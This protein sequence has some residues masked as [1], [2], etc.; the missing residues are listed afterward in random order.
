MKAGLTQKEIADQL[1]RNPSAISRELKRNLG[2]RGYRPAQ[3]QRFRDNRKRN[4]HKAIKLT[5]E[6]VCWIKKLLHQELSPQQVVDYLDKHKD[7]SLHHET[8]YQLIYK[9]KASG[10]NLHQHLRVAS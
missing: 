1:N 9:E 7:V 5:D 6:V 8:I 4:A 10:G 2:L 3:L